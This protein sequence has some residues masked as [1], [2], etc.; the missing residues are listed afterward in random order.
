[1]GFGTH[2][3][4]LP[5]LCTTIVRNQKFIDV[6]MDEDVS[7]AFDSEALNMLTCKRSVHRGRRPLGQLCHCGWRG[8]KWDGGS[9]L[10]R[11]H[12]RIFSRTVAQSYYIIGTLGTL[13]MK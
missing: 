11:L 10:F 3:F 8:E 13:V 7:T 6:A 9:R 12:D 1:M 5:L 4:E 2:H